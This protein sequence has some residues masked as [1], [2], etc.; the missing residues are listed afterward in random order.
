MVALAVLLERQAFNRA[1]GEGVQLAET[2]ALV[3]TVK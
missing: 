1:V 3:V 2:Q